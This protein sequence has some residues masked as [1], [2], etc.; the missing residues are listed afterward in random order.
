MVHSAE[1]W[2]NDSRGRLQRSPFTDE[3]YARKGWI[4]FG[5]VR[6]N[7]VLYNHIIMYLCDRYEEIRIYC[8]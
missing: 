7:I 3:D 8:I 2:P 6:I 5:W 4:H 1:Q